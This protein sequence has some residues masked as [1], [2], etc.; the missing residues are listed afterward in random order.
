MVDCPECGNLLIVKEKVAYATYAGSLSKAQC[1][2][3][4]CGHTWFEEVE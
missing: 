1:R 2:C 3:L 4:N